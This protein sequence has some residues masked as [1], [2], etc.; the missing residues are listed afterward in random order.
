MAAKSSAFENPFGPELFAFVRDLTANN[1]REWFQQNKRRYEQE[2]KEPA[3][4]FISGFGPHLRKI[5]P[6]FLA[7]PKAQGGSLF[8]IHRDT[9]FSSDK[10]P[11]KTHVGIH[12]RHAQ[13]ADAHTPG[14]YL[15]LQPGESFVGMG[16]WHPDAPTLAKIRGAMVADAAAW[17]KA[18]ASFEKRFALAGESLKK[19][20]Q[21]FDAG[22]PLIDDLRRKDFIG[23]IT[24][25]DAEV[26]DPAFPARFVDACR[27]GAGLVRWLC[28]ALEVPF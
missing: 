11:Y 19:A 4:A 26:L 18:K 21:G 5:S 22:H 23:A 10:S 2:V 12:F 1:D 17:K 3:L 25:G 14:F 6:H 28:G 24:H 15:H 13:G 20:P 7:I 8:R 16:L 27:D 9:R